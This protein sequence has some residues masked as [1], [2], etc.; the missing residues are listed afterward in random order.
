MQGLNLVFKDARSI[1][2]LAALQAT[3]YMHRYGISS[4]QCAQVVVR[5][6]EMLLQSM[7]NH[8]GNMTDVLGSPMLSDP[9]RLLDA[10]HF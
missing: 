1:S 7:P 4:Q 8:P 10:N 5:T 3:Q 6:A 2:L 9:I